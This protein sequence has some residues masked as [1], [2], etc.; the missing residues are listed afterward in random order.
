MCLP[1]RAVSID[2]ELPG[3]LERLTGKVAMVST[4]P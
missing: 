1:E 4:K 2:T 3:P